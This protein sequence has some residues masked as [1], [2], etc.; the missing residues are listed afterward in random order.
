MSAQ[1]TPIGM[2]V[3]PAA[4]KRNVMYGQSLTRLAHLAWRQI[5]LFNKGHDEF[6]TVAIAVD[7]RWRDLVDHLMPN[8]PESHWQA[9]RDQGIE[10]V[11]IGSVSRVFCD[12]F[13]AE[14][15]DIAAVLMAPPGDGFVKCIAVDDGGCTVYDLLPAENTSRTGKS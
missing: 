15:T 8:T 11:A 3:S 2:D 4:E 9:M 14:F 13:A 7:S 10:P 1:S 6:V 5:N 12:F